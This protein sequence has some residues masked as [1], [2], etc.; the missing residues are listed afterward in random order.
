[1]CENVISE[2]HTLENEAAF[3]YLKVEHDAVELNK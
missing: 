2:L 1:M 3:D